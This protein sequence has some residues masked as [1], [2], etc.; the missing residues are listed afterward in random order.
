MTYVGHDEHVEQHES[1]PDLA[2]GVTREVLE[3]VHGQV[4]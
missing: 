2:V 1:G 4:A 3:G